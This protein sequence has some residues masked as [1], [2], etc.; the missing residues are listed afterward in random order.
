[1]NRGWTD[2]CKKRESIRIDPHIVKERAAVAAVRE[3]RKRMESTIKYVRPELLAVT[4]VLYWIGM[5][6]KRSQLVRDKYIPM[7]LGAIGVLICVL[8][9]F[10][11][12]SC[13]SWREAAMAAFTSITQGI[14]VAGLS[15]YVNQLVK[16]AG[17]EE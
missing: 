10:A 12:C 3:R 5:G 1:M 9:I 11:S 8:Y 6:L 16:Q 7:I 14:L 13:A 17:K 4:V 2:L 15:T